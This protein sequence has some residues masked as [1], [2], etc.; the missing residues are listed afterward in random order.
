MRAL[1]IQKAQDLQVV[2]LPLPELGP[3]DVQVDVEW[4]GICGSDLGYWRHGA[5]GTAQMKR[6]FVLGHEVSG[7]IRAI[8]SRVEGLSVG[9]G[10]TVHPARTTGPLPE[11]LQGRGNLHPDL[12]YL[13]SAMRDPHT[14]GGF[15]QVLQVQASQIVPLPEGLDTRRAVLAEP[16]GVAMHAVH[17]AGDIEGAHVLVSG[18]GPVGL[19]VIIA[20]RAAGAAHVTAIDLAEPARAQALAVGAD[21]ATDTPEGMDEQISVAFECSGAPASL[22]GI[23]RHIPRASTI[24]QVG[25]LPVAPVTVSLGP[26]VSKEIDYRGTFRFVAEIEDAVRLLAGSDVAEKVISHEFPLDEA[27][28]AFSTAATDPTS[29][30]VIL[31]IA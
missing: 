17:R 3:D 26:I 24:V 14:D 22:D 4:G 16:L 25:N 6:P 10:V 2:D 11:R 31:R 27:E 18:C 7:R 9:Q 21:T 28:S 1:Q 19:L 30:K 13:G 15:S 8:G 29:S 23:I 20:A 12:T 5:T